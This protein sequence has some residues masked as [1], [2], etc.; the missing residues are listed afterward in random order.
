MMKKTKRFGLLLIGF[1]LAGQMAAA[2]TLVFE[3][4]E[5][6]QSGR[7]APVGW[8]NL[9][10]DRLYSRDGRFAVQDFSFLAFDLGRK[11]EVIHRAGGFVVEVDVLGFQRDAKWAGIG[12]GRETEP[13]EELDLALRLQSDFEL[14]TP[15]RA[16]HH[17]EGWDIGHAYQEGQHVRIEVDTRGVSVEG[18]KAVA[19]VYFG[20][21]PVIENYQF[22]WGDGPTYVSFHSKGGAFYDNLRIS[23]PL[24]RVIARPATI[25]TDTISRL[26]NSRRLFSDSKGRRPIRSSGR[27]L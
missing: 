1:G 12:I 8:F 3:P 11:P 19:T 16:F 18:E 2:E 22:K 21:T 17:G 23:S 15:D 26:G 6:E 7:W 10:S 13:L 5:G 24:M 20:E 25:T 14:K 9:D 27:L 4:F